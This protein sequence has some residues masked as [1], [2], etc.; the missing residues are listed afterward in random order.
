MAD[1]SALT[2][3]LFE[4]FD[5]DKNGVL[6]QSEIEVFFNELIAS[7]SELALTA[8]DFEKWYNAIDENKNGTITPDELSRYLASINFTA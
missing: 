7:R 4:K 2:A 8:D 5:T 1:Y 6:K 3:S